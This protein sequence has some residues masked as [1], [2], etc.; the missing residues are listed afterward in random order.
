MMQ[1]IV[2]IIVLKC[3]LAHFL[4]SWLSPGNLWCDRKL[5][6]LAVVKNIKIVCLT[7]NRL[8]FILDYDNLPQLIGIVLSNIQEESNLILIKREQDESIGFSCLSLCS[9]TSFICSAAS[10][11]IFCTSCVSGLS[12][13][14]YY[15]IPTG[16]QSTS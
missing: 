3:E 4:S 9:S 13:T 6:H 8:A 11:G 12:V 2:H 10:V 1:H 14:H 15:L 16:L 7:C 5:L